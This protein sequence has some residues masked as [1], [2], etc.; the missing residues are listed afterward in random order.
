MSQVNLIKAIQEDLSFVHELIED[1]ESNKIDFNVFQKVY[2][3][4]LN[5]DQIHYFIIKADDVKIGFISIHFQLLLHHYGKVAEIQ[6]IIFTPS[7]RGKGF[8]KIVLQEATQFAKKSDCVLIELSANK[9]RLD[10]HRFYS[11]ENWKQS[12]FKFTF[13]L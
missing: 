1:L 10:A 13:D 6:E 11:R 12:H 5:N 4:N 8:G 9:K 2:F 3:E 7:A